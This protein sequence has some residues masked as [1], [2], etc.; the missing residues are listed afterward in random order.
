M[1]KIINDLSFYFEDCYKE[2]SVREYSREVRVSPPTASKMLNKFVSEGFLKRREERG[3]LLFRVNRENLIMR[4]LSRIYW[5]EKLKELIGFLGDELYSNS[6]ILFGSLSKLEVTKE[7]DIDIA[8]FSKSEKK[9]N[10]DKSEKKLGRKIQVFVF[11][12]LEK[13]NK[14][15]RNNIMNGYV[16]EGYLA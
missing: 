4:D 16:L 9:I 11:E 13:V 15:L 6:I 3:F 8:V 2:F 10:I 14:E 1:L 5:S 7:S 12:S